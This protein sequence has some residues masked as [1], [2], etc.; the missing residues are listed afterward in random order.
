M[1]L[2]GATGFIGRRLLDALLAAGYDVT[3]GVRV[4]TALPQCR[5]ITVDFARDHDEKDWL[6]RLSGIDFVVNAV[7]ILRETGGATFEALHVAAPVALFRASAKAGVRKIVQISA[8]GA[9]EHAVSRYHLSKKRAD[10]A[11]AALG[12]PWVIVQPSLVFGEGGESAALF[13]RLAALPVIPV[14]GDGRQQIQPVHIDDLTAGILRLL[15][16]SQHDRQRIAAVGPRALAFRDFLAALRAAMGLG[17]ARFLNVPMVFVRLAA[18][19]GDRMSGVL[20]DRESLGMLLRGNVAPAAQFS[21]V[22]SHAPRP[23]ERFIAPPSARALANDARLGWLLPLLRYSVAFVW[24]A[25]AI[26]SLGF[27]PVA[28]SYALLARVGLTGAIASIALYGAALLD[29]VFGIGILVMRRRLWLWRAQMLLIAG[30]TVIISFHLPEF[31]LHPYGPLTKNLPML[32]GIVM[33][34]EFDRD[35][36]KSDRRH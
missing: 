25:T 21:A 22:L 19:A 33:L 6:P 12:V 31:W 15:E 34:H 7:G 2:F 18:A 35:S 3:C 14:P 1:L 5:C 23:V 8:L 28:D 20:L 27:Y 13:S 36:L 26:V 11:L 32:A 9:D 17:N 4:I 24:I 16:T 10:D 30:Y 29:L